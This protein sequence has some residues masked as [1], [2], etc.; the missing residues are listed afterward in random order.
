MTIQTVEKD[1]WAYQSMHHYLW[2]Q[3]PEQH[4]AIY[5][6]R[7]VDHDEDGIALSRRIYARYP[8]EF[9]LI[10]KVEPQPKR[11]LRFR[12]PRFVKE[13]TSGSQL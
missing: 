11:T 9:V 13:Q 4:V 12:S 1:K 6:G 8:D 2:S 10:K 7:L 3:Y 5:N